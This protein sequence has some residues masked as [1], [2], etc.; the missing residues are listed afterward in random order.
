MKLIQEYTF[1]VIIFIISLTIIMEISILALLYLRASQIFMTTYQ[2][3]ITESETKLIEITKKIE[4]H[5]SNIIIKYL[6]DL[7]LMGKH[8]LLLNGKYGK[9]YSTEINKESNLFKINDKKKYII[10]AEREILNQKDYIRRMYNETEDIFDYLQKYEEN[11]ENITE[12][13]IILKSLFSNSH[14]ELNTI[15]YYCPSRRES[16]NKLEIK[17]MISILKTI[18]VRRYIGKRANMDYIRFIILNND[19]IYIYP[20]ETFNST[21]MYNFQNYCPYPYSDCIYSSNNKSQQFPLC[22]YNYIT[23]KLMTSDDNYLSIIYE[24]IIYDKIYVDLCLKIPLIKNNKNQA[25]ACIELEFSSLFKSFNFHYP[26]KFEFGLITLDDYGTII[27]LIYN[28]KFKNG[29]L[30]NI[31]ND[32]V[33]EKYVI[34][35]Y[36]NVYYLFHYLYYNLTIIAKE[37]PELNINFTD[38]E[39]EYNII[40]NKIL[41][42][43]KQL[44]EHNNTGVIKFTFIKTICRKKLLRNTFECFKDE[45]EMIIVSLELNIKKL[46]EDIIET[47]DNATSNCNLYVYSIIATNPYANNDVIS[48]ILRIKIERTI[49][50]FFF[51]TVIIMSFYILLIDIISGFSLNPI[52]KIINKLKNININ[53]DSKKFNTLE[54][55]KVIAPNKEISELK[56]IYETMRKS[57]I[58]KQVFDKEYFLDKHKLEFYHLVQDIDKKNIKEICNSYLGFYHYKNGSYSLAETELKSTISFIQD[59]LNRVTSGKSS[60]YED[61]IKDAIKRSSTVSYINE[62]SEFQKIEENLLTIINL[63]IFKQRF[64]YLYAMTKFKLGNEIN[65]NNINHSI[66]PI[67]NKKK[68]LKDKDKRIEYFKKAINYFNECKNINILLGINQIKIIYF[69]IMISKCYI[70]LNNYKDA[71]NNINEALS[72]YFEFSKTFKDYHSKN[73]NPRIMLFV[74]NNI[75]QYILFTIERICYSFNKPFAYNWIILKLFETSPFLIGNVHYYS[76]IFI[77][78]FLERNKLKLNKADSKFLTNSTL[79]KEYEKTKKYYSKIVQRMNIKNRNIKYLK[80]ETDKI[81]GDSSDYSTSYKNKTE[82]KTEKS[83]FSSSFTREMA[84]SKISSSFHYKNKNLSKVITL[85]LSEKILEKVNG[86]ELKD[87]IIKYF[88]KY[89]IMNENDKF[90]FIQF[91]NNGKKTVHFKMEQLDYFLLKI[92]K[93]KNTFELTDSFMTNSNLPFM[94][95]YNIFDSIIKNYPSNEDTDNIIIMFIN[96]DDIRF[97]SEN[98]CLNIVE[99]LNKKNTSIYLLSYDDEIKKEKINNI[100]S[101]L[102][103]LFEGYFFQIKNYQQLKQ[104][105]INLSTIK[106]QSNFFGYDYYSLDNVL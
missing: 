73:Y 52:D 69:L 79:L 70:Q 8:A 88:Q 80:I 65:N 82:S 53:N 10:N 40:N 92:Q 99:E 94:E 66:S 62:Y 89:F 75:F 85:C 6:T 90:S 44:N 95:L 59:N 37:H 97:T 41:Y 11:F 16:N 34:N 38:I 74:E 12:Q 14:Q 7:K 47:I 71:I 19:E 24:K 25:V 22:V 35:E 63:N 55:D 4:N 1:K 101:F 46:N 36:N 86:L 18:F 77:Q 32:T 42:E 45:F 91:A 31:Y 2:Q 26:E 104:I 76:A 106:Y 23:T 87:V 96:S 13:N 105:F 27:P 83:I 67:Q 57:L 100:R 48:V 33:T 93:N 102:D 54:E 84:T 103:G 68:S 98:E 58:I 5:S 9:N 30:R 28:R 61:K 49:I 72:L 15:S 60:E 51:L 78:N 50:L 21:N 3:T 39:E 20:P 43:I 17:F 56:N 29:E 64:I 81:N